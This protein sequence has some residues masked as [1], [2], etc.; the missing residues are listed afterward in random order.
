[1]NMSH[2]ELNF[3]N[4]SIGQINL[5]QKGESDSTKE[6]TV[7]EIETDQVGT[8]GETERGTNETENSQANGPNA[9]G[10]YQR[11]S[12]NAQVLIICNFADKDLIGYKEDVKMLKN[13]WEEFGCDVIVKKNRNAKDMKM[14]IYSFAYETLSGKEFFVAVFVLSHGKENDYIQG[15]DK[16]FI[17]VSE[18]LGRFTNRN[19]NLQDVPKLFF[20]Q[21]CRGNESNQGVLYTKTAGVRE[22]PR[23]IPQVCD[24]L[25]FYPT[26]KGTTAFVETTG[27]WFIQALIKV[28]QENAQ[29]KHVVDM[30]TM[31]NRI[32]AEK[33]ARND[34]EPDIDGAKAMS[35]FTSTLRDDVYMLGRPQ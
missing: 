7:S 27:S 29:K 9:S 2:N 23:K 22:S 5:N 18:I 26:Q 21:I 35:E 19:V 20:F 28:F 16:N 3:V 14:D 12:N 25:V 8:V 4:S 34:K 15:E 1:M 11:G 24:T 17:H 32:M 10:L 13:M 6:G 33:T 31:V 30:L